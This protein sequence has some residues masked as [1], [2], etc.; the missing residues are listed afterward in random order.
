MISV[1]ST[2][3][4]CFC[5]SFFFFSRIYLFGV[6]SIIFVIGNGGFRSYYRCTSASCNVKKR[7]ERS[8]KDPTIV[9]TT[10]EG[11]HTH[12]SPIMPRSNPS[13]IATTFA[14]PMI[15]TTPFQHH[16]HPSLNEHLQLLNYGHAHGNNFCGSVQ[17]RRF[18][19]PTSSLLR[20]HG[21]LQ[22]IVPSHMRK[23]EE[24]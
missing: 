7:V 15:Q 14:V 8:F 17:E 2:T 16:Q 10:Y 11:Q 20:D 21:L 12:P 6:I 23:E 13:A 3:I 19:A 5:F 22:D 18:C 24:L 1:S 4:F 9:V